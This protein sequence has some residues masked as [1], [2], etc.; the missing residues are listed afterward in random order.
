MPLLATPVVRTQ[1]VAP[2]SATA[3]LPETNLTA[4]AH[5]LGAVGGRYSE[6]TAVDGSV[7]AGWLRTA[8][9]EFHAFAYDLAA[10]EPAMLDLGT[11]GG[12]SSE[13]AAVAGVA[14]ETG[15]ASPGAPPGA[16]RRV[17]VVEDNPVNQMVAMG[18]LE[19][20]GYDADTADD[21]VAAI[22]MYAEGKYDLILMDVQMPRLDGY[23]ATR[24]LRDRETGTAHVPILA[25][26]A[27]AVAG[28]RER[29]LEAGMDD[30][31]TKPVDPDQL[32]AMLRHWLAGEP[33]PVAPERPVGSVTR[34]EVLDLDRLDMLR[35]MAEG[36][37][38]YLDR[39]IDNFAANRSD[40]LAAIVAAVKSADAAALQHAAHRLAG[41][42]LNLGLTVAGERARTLELVADQGT[43]AGADHLL[44]G[45]T[46]ALETGTDA[47]LAYRAAYQSL[48]GASVAAEDRATVP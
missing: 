8:S 26:T 29:C 44:P 4:T 33:G 19:A 13:A 23:G 30:F 35:D 38:A 2:T 46:E 5:D 45:L 24:A 47:L 16:R 36:N 40:S 3:A 6:A 28:E 27:S 7:V 41:S 34:M 20:L 25:M 17:L 48:A 9:G 10:A 39:A 12:T 21:G 22:E 18:L 14:P 15:V 1:A 32:A 37:T 31:I 42:A 43:T 11:L